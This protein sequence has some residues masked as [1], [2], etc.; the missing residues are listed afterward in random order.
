MS[1]KPTAPAASTSPSASAAPASSSAAASPAAPP[2]RDST[3]NGSLGSRVAVA[4]L[5]LAVATAVWWTARVYAPAQARLAEAQAETARTL[6]RVADDFAALR[7]RVDALE[8]Q[9]AGHAPALAALGDTVETLER[10][11]SDAGAPALP[12]L[13]L[14]RI[15]HQVAVA[16]ARLTLAR[17]IDGA[18]AALG[19]AGALLDPDVPAEAGYARVLTAAQAALA[20]VQQPDVAALAARWARHATAVPALAF[21]DSHADTLPGSALPEGA[22]QDDTSREGSA[23]PG[24]RPGVAEDGAGDARAATPA[25]RRLLAAVWQDLRGLIEVRRL[26]TAHEIALDPAQH[27][28]TKSALQMEIAT[29][30]AALHARDTTGM[31][32]AVAF[33]GHLLDRYYDAQQPAVVAMRADLETLASLDLA[34]PLPSLQ[35]SLAGLHELRIRLQPSSGSPPALAPPPAAPAVSLPAAPVPPA[36]TDAPEVGTQAP[37]GPRDIM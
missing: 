12:A 26:D 28:L 27:A 4:G 20:A 18:S 17:D 25:W 14:A 9:Q 3:R 10:R 30:R 19:A 35:A 6:A 33:L 2:R 29:L 21:R 24:P 22:A 1:S 16:D 37:L 15:E 36:A 5:V 11:V 31:Q 13:R 23:T 8:T 7:A 32:A 34:P